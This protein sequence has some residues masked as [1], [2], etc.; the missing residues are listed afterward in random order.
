ML[1]LAATL[2][3]AAFAVSVAADPIRGDATSTGINV[4]GG[5]CSFTNYT[6]PPGLYGTGLGPSNWAGGSKC[7]SCLQVTGEKTGRSVV[8]TD[9]C[10]SCTK[11]RLNLFSDAF[12]QIA[13]PNDGIIN[14][15]YEPV[16]CHL[17]SPLVLRTK[18]GSSRWFFSVQVLSANFPVIA[19]DVSND[20]LQTWQPTVRMDYNFFEK[21]GKGGFDK[22]VVAVRVTCSNG[23]T[24]V[25]PELRLQEKTSIAAPVNC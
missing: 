24:V 3:Y 17:S 10:P 14:I 20:N 25:V 22:D 8:V 9:S 21:D 19:L 7:G 4:Q 2:L 6:L 12:S 18:E 1:R 13:N 11:N 23:R 15:Q 16:S 5:T